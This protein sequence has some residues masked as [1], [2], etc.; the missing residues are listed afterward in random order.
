MKKLF[1]YTTRVLVL[2][3]LYS[4]SDSY[5]DQ[6]P[7]DQFTE[8]VF[9]KQAGDFEK[10]INAAYASL[11]TTYGNFYA[12][13]DIA[14]D[15]AYN[16][17]NNNN[18]DYISINESNVSPDNN[19]INTQW[20]SGYTTIARANIVLDRIGATQVEESLK[21]RYTG[22]AQ[23][24]RALAYFNLVRIFGEIPLVLNEIK[25]ADEAFAR[26]RESVPDVYDLIIAD[27]KEAE[28]NLPEAYQANADIGRATSLAAKGLLGKVYLTRKMYT[29]A[30]VKFR[31]VIS[32]RKYML[33]NDYSNIFDPDNPNNAEVIFA[34]QYARNQSPAQGSAF[35]NHVAPNEPVGRA[36][37]SAGS[38][39][40]FFHMTVGLY[41][42]FE[43]GDRRKAM[44]DS[45]DGAQTLR[46]YYF[47]KKYFDP[48]MV[49]SGDAANDWLVLRYAD[50]LLMAAEALNETEG[51]VGSESLGY[52]NQVRE[53]AGL[54]AIPQPVGSS[55]FRI[56]IERE[57]RVE[58]NCEG[59]RW[60]DL[61]RTGRAI[62]VMNQYFKAF[63]NDQ[64][65][66]GQN[67]SIQ[68]YE[69]VF[70]LP[71]SQVV[72]NPDK[73]HQNTGY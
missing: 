61:V 22:E 26:G 6:Y 41:K 55:E 13:G 49:K 24:L 18:F 25:H 64:H 8:G 37:V 71:I 29:E 36:I 21:K 59:H 60:F 27:L 20:N 48:G 62:E 57:R 66:V 3:S 19:V 58:L 35:G 56:I 14:S 15:D 2:L 40:G 23:F 17:K 34:V 5:F 33:L 73:I 32:S 69:L 63:E 45:A 7:E 9:Y 28:K 54:G 67:S 46:R 68:E 11:R 39:N 47:T 31:E 10:A 72:L 52:V 70:P 53:R 1:A 51:V 4:C 42:A 43:S 12:L 16:W 38:G 65:E 44:V 50:I 30:V